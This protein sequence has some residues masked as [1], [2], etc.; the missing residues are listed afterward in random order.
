MAKDN[1][2]NTENLN[3]ETGAE[4]PEKKTGFFRRLLA[5]LLVLA[6][7]LM[8]AVLTT[9]GDGNYFSALR[10]WLIY[11]DG[12]ETRHL[13]TYSADQGNLYGQL[14]EDLL[15]VGPNVIQLLKDNGTVIYEQ[16]V[17]LSA[18]K[19]SM[20]T[21]Q[22]AVCDVG[23]DTLYILDELG[24]VRTDTLERGLVYYSVRMNSKDY[25]AV[26]SQ[27]SGYKGAVA[28]YDREGELLFRFDSSDSYI[29]DA[30][31][32][33]DGKTLLAVALD[34]LD[35]AFASKLLVYDM[36]SAQRVA[37]YAI[38]DGLV[39]DYVMQGD[40]VLSLCD[41]RLTISTLAGETLLDRA[42]GNLYLHDY[43]LTGE[44][45]CALLLGRYQ[46]GNIGQLITY[47]LE[48]QEIAALEISEE[49]LD[50]SAAGKH[51]A[52]LYS[53]SLVLYTRDLQEVARLDGTDY[54]GQVQLAP[55]GTALVI[56]GTSAWH[57]L[58]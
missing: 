57:Y 42:Y 29:S 3:I 7:V 25:L 15:V 22:A 19:L 35:G 30:V 55:D 1:R 10:R 51:L 18:P 58:P 9:M 8:V 23:G 53:D 47:D 14:G 28:V 13:Y 20:G 46:A 2:Q 52:V 37:E 16:Q 34:T 31:V 49:V 12:G 17:G 40:R 33:E 24:I 27:K 54:A 44:D 38:W 21:T 5:L 26:T 6:V 39:L 4:K 56:A 41:K 45:F 48:G 32:S 50:I 11:G 43:A 36:A